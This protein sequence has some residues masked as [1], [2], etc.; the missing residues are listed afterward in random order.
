MMSHRRVFLLS[1][2]CQ[3]VLE[4]E[5]DGVAAQEHLC[6]ETILVDGFALLLTLAGLRDLG[7]HLLHL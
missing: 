7:P 4:D 1:S 5:D 6:D 3:R 2:G